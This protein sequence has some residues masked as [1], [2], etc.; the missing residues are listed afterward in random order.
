MIAVDQTGIDQLTIA[1]MKNVRGYY[2]R[3]P[4]GKDRD[5]EILNAAAFVVAKILAA[6]AE[7]KERYHELWNYFDDCCSRH[8]EDI[9][10]AEDR[11]GSGH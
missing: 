11:Y 6:A 9:S 5:F 1:F 2:K 3:M 4:S 7:N 10:A 8:V